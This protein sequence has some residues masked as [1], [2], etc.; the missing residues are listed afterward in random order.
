MYTCLDRFYFSF[1]FI[2]PQTHRLGPGMQLRQGLG[3]LFLFPPPSGRRPLLLLRWT[4]I[5]GAPYSINKIDPEVLVRIGHNVELVEGD[6]RDFLKKNPELLD[7]LLDSRVE[8]RI[9]NSPENVLLNVQG[10]N[11]YKRTLK[12][13]RWS[14][15]I[16][17][18]LRHK[19]LKMQV[20]P[21]PPI[22][23]TNEEEVHEPPI[24]HLRWRLEGTRRTIWAAP[25]LPEP[26]LA[27]HSY[28]H[29][30]RA[31]GKVTL[32]VIDRLV[33]PAVRA[34]WLWWYIERFRIISTAPPRPLVD[35]NKVS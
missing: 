10:P 31:T 15:K 29:F 30:D 5:M 33:P 20:T 21:V 6:T 34:G 2:S 19:D 27:G 32:H 13:I 7:G 28:Y 23:T 9:Q 18:G 25:T 26:L 35:S 12:I 3:T 16:W 11:T 4:F 17:Y 8:L 1:I 14:M 22:T 24:F